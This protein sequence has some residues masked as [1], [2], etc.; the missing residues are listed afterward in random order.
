MANR[1]FFE[2]AARGRGP[3]VL[4]AV[5]LDRNMLDLVWA[6]DG[7]SVG[8]GNDRVHVGRKY[9]AIMAA[10]RGGHSGLVKELA[11]LGANVQALEGNGEDA[12]II[13][14]SRGHVAVCSVLLDHGAVV[15]TKTA[16]GCTALHYS[17]RVPTPR[18]SS[19]ARTRTGLAACR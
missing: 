18:K 17:E 1:Q 14:S 16:S 2:D 4:A 12:L 11:L 5:G 13:A 19:A 7:F 3:Q 8:D 6:G 15:T 9:T 10:S